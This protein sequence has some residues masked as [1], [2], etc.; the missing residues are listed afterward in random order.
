M[1]IFDISLKWCSFILLK[2]WDDDDK[3]SSSSLNWNL[4]M[5]SN[6]FRADN[7][8]FELQLNVLNF[9]SVSKSDHVIVHEV[10]Y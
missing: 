9:I 8:K 5:F 2:Y 4:S 1:S 6:S 7:T 10:S 3:F